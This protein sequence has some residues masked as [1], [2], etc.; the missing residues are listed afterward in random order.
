MAQFRFTVQIY[1]QFTVE[2]ATED[3]AKK[4]AEEEVK[5]SGIIDKFNLGQPKDLSKPDKKPK[6]GEKKNA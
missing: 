4:L 3:E 2:A 6:G 1:K 5:K